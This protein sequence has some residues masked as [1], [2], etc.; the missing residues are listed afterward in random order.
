M[1]PLDP[2]LDQALR[3][4]RSLPAYPENL[5]YAF[6]TRFLSRLHASQ[7]VPVPW[8][9]LSWQSLPVCGIL[10]LGSVAVFAFTSAL[11]QSAWML[12]YYQGGES[13]LLNLY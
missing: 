8:W 13:W 7:T 5:E 3:T 1:N 4:L 12:S 6:E 10:A 9:I 11:V 2:R